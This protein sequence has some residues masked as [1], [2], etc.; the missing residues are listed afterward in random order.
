MGSSDD[1][2]AAD[3]AADEEAKP[4]RANPRPKTTAAQFD[5]WEAYPRRKGKAEACQQFMKLMPEDAERAI[6]AAGAYARECLAE[7]RE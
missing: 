4:K 1:A 5:R 3:Q 2:A 7:H 6:A